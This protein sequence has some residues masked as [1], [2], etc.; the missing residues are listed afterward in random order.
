MGRVSMP[1]GKGSQLHNR[2]EYEKIGRPVPDNIDSS[3]TTENIILVDKDVRQAYQEIFGKALEEYNSKQKR[4]DRKI[5]DYYDHILKSKNGE[6][7][8]Y[9]DVVQWGKKEDFEN[10]ETR[11]KAKEALVK[12]VEGFEERNKNLKIIGAYI[13][14]DEASPHLH[15]DY[16]P[17]ASGYSI[18]MKKRNS[19]DR[20][21]KQMG[22]QPKS[23]S[24]MNNAT[25]LWK[26]H[27][28]AVFGQLCRDVGL[29]VDAER[30]SDRKSLT[31]DEYRDARDE[32]IGHIEQEKEAIIK[33]LQPLREIKTG[34]DDIAATTGKKLPF[35]V[36]AIDAEKLEAIKDQAK[37]YMANRDEIRELRERAAAISAKEQQLNEREQDIKNQEYWTRRMYNTQ[38]NLNQL[39]QK[40]KS[41]ASDRYWKITKLEHE[42]SSLHGEVRTLTDQLDRSKAE[43]NSL[44]ERL[45]GSQERLSEV[46]QAV[47][48]IKGEGLTQEQERLIQA[49][50]KY[51]TKCAKEAGFPDMAKDMEKN[52]ISKGLSKIMVRDPKHS[53][54]M[55]R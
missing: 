52:E 22:F 5:A 47:G 34:I 3:K 43:I 26:D 54:D 38:R 46:I 18:G 45:K 24:R 2:R 48:V 1:Q 23:E 49:I 9:E 33:E 50:K 51:G 53:W 36:V 29:E 37:A 17:I 4:N 35:G 27:E 21:M 14:M 40:E 25:K 15:L 13:H 44:R 20:A 7:P 30:K 39:Y 28:R 11:E 41:A 32:M 16:I 10:P 6:K 42:N 55:E 19:L 31:A 8:F 12:Y